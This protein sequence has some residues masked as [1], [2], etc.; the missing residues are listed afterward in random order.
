MRNAKGFTLI[1]L[2]IVVAIIA[3]I[4]SIAIPNLLSAR[5]NAN[6]A[7][8]I[9]TLRNVVSAQSQVQS[10]GAIDQDLDGIGEH[11]WF[12]EMSGNIGL[13]DDTG[14]VGA[15]L[16]NPPVLSS[17]LG[18]VDG[19]GFVN[20]SGYFFMML[21]PA[22]LGAPL[23]EVGGGG[24]PTGED[25]DLCENTWACY[26]WPAAFANT[27]NRAFV[28]NQSGDVLQTNNQDPATQQYSGAGNP[29]GGDAA[30]T[31]AGDITSPLSIGGLPGAAQ[32]GGTWLVV[33]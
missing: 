12:A 10:Q 26:A 11:G 23:N 16:L 1:E 3:I 30:Y 19:N 21:L 17:A 22:A 33:N 14:A 8:A 7:A 6:E 5:L 31:A 29:P 9:A 28:V 2:M 18:R 24:T 32:D 25:F 13:R 20:R 4:A 15:V 27:G